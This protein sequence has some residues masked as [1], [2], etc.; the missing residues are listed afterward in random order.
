MTTEPF[1]EVPN[2]DVDGTGPY[3]IPHEYTAGA[4]KPVIE[5]ADGDPIELIDGDFTVDPVSGDMGNL[6]LSAA[7]AA[8]QAGGRLYIYRETEVQQGWVGQNSAREKGLE[9]QLDLTAQG[10]QDAL[11]AA[12][13]SLRV[14][15]GK[16]APLAMSDGRVPIWNEEKGGFDNGPSADEVT[17]AQAYAEE[18]E[19]IAGLFGDVERAIE[20]TEAARDKAEQWAE[21]PEDDPVD[22]GAFSAKHWAAKSE[23]TYDETAQLK[24]DVELI[25]IYIGSAV[26]PIGNM[27]F[28]YF[29]EVPDGWLLVN[30]QPV[31]PDMPDLRQKLIDDGAPLDGNGDPLLS[32]PRGRVVR[33][34][35]PDGNLDP[36]VARAIRSFQDDALQDHGHTYTGTAA[37]DGSGQSTRTYLI[38][39]DSGGVV[40][41]VPVSTAIDDS[42]AARIS[43]E[44]RMANA[45]YPM[46]IK[47]YHAYANLAGKMVPLGTAA[48]EDVEA[49]ATALEGASVPFARNHLR[50]GHGAQGSEIFQNTNLKPRVT[51]HAD[52][53][54]L[55]VVFAHDFGTSAALTS[56]F[57]RHVLPSD[58]AHG[59]FVTASVL[60]AS[61]SGGD[62]PAGN[63]VAYVYDAPT[64]GTNTQLITDRIIEVGFDQVTPNLRRYWGRWKLPDIGVLGAFVFGFSGKITTGTGTIGG[65]ELYTGGA[66]IPVN[67]ARRYDWDGYSTSEAWRKERAASDIAAQEDA[68]PGHRLVNQWINPTLDPSIGEPTLVGGGLSLVETPDNSELVE[69][70]VHRTIDLG[71]AG[72]YEVECLNPAMSGQQALIGSYVSSSDGETWP[73]QFS[74]YWYDA[75]GL[76]GNLFILTK[77][78]QVRPGLRFYY[79]TGT[80]PVSAS[81]SKLRLGPSAAVTGATCEMGGFCLVTSENPISIHDVSLRDWYGTLTRPEGLLATAARVTGVERISLQ[82]LEHKNRAASPTLDEADGGVTTS[83]A[84]VFVQV[85]PSSTEMID[86]GIKRTIGFTIGGGGGFL[87]DECL[88]PDVDGNDLFFAVYVYSSDGA[89]WI[90]PQVYLLRKQRSDFR[91]RR[92][93]QLHPDQ[94]HPSTLLCGGYGARQ[95]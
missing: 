31:T 16:I 90:A 20:G 24:A 50:D 88:G 81:L 4:I 13:R 67:L 30:G 70:G 19:R 17:A 76:L 45:A 28:H 95:R 62:W 22:P 54:G 53:A 23:E 83:G 18:A 25:K 11:D 94:Q 79:A 48:E 47:A 41:D 72:F 10:T 66:Q 89:N 9:R 58:T 37:N 82:D 38:F 42:G 74:C 52:L 35:D 92:A 32:D 1:T 91:Q 40:S 75:G 12:G 29:D 93:V 14:P 64:G 65:W 21:N 68:L 46:I 3:S 36:E 87:V 77:F 2:Y 86:L 71:G 33:I 73:V 39:D 5:V 57:I 61:D 56:I 7:I 27:T 8:D 34:W 6:F 59:D 85:P 63:L 15:R 84:G 44:T 60:V 55:G 51:P 80:L 26:V 43:T 69:R 78:L 49:F